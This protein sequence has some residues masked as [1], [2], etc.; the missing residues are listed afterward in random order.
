MSGTEYRIASLSMAPDD[1][2]CSNRKKANCW[3][4]C[5]F[6]TGHGQRETV[7]YYR[8]RKTKLWHTNKAMFLSTLD[9]ELSQHVR[10]SIKAGKIPAARLNTISD[11]SWELYDIY[12]SYPDLY[13]YD[14]TKKPERLGK[15]PPNYRLMFSYSAEPDYKREVDQALETGAPIAVCFRGGFPEEFLGRE[16]IDG[17][18]SD[19]FNLEAHNKIIGLKLKGGPAI[20]SSQ[21]RFIVNNPEMRVES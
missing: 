3:K 8:R 5:L 4:E 6:N 11:I 2:I 18:K 12:Q 10:A 9:L 15:T 7:K 21:S 16:V 13:G 20:Q 19:L 1:I 14:Y 17:D